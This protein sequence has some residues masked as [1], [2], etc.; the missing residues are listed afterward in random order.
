MKNYR[1]ISNL[2]FLSKTLER[3]VATRIKEHLSHNSLFDPFQSAYRTGH[4][5]ET[6]LLRVTND[7]LCSI[8]DANNSTALILLDLSAAF[9][10]VNH[11]LLIKRLQMYGIGGPALSWME[12]Y[13]SNRSQTVKLSESCHS[14]P[15]RLKTGVPQGSVLGPLLFSIYMRPLGELILQYG[16]QYHLYA[17][18]SQLYISFSEDNSLDACSRLQRCI[19]GIRQWMSESFLLLN[20]S[21]TEFIIFNSKKDYLLPSFDHVQVGDFQAE[22]SS[23]ARNLGVT[24]DSQLSMEKHITN[25]CKTAY[26]FLRSIGRI[27]KF[28]TQ[29]DAEK[30]VHAFITSRLDSCNSLLAGLSDKSISRLQKV[31]N[32][33]ARVVT[34]SRKFDHITP[35]LRDLHWLPIRQRV[36]Y[37]VMI[38]NFKCLYGL[39]PGYL[40]DLVSWYVPHRP[41]RSGEKYLMKDTFTNGS[42]RR[43]KD[44]A[45]QNYGPRLWNSMPQLVRS[46]T[47]FS[48]FKSNLKTHLFSVVFKD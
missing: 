4:S 11:Q 9:D 35:V 7:I 23:S 15:S 25:T 27:R 31:Q 13:L 1:P 12:S 10:T 2:S 30:L 3:V 8:D 18:D 36:D 42:K 5:T 20:N 28:L 38:M 32:A 44:R 39:A 48:T 19:D 47:T 46:I 21:K 6:A 40:S 26:Y 37:K 41:L 16:I 34:K 43:S 24:F 45:F 29:E 17:D 22:R 33:A 14:Q